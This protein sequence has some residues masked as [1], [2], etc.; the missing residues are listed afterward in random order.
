MMIT[1]GMVL[2]ERYEILG[3]IGAGGMADVY[4]GMD[5]KLNRYV[6][7]KVLKDEFAENHSFVSKFRAEA[8]A[9]AGLIH[10]N[11]VNVY[12]VGNE[13]GLYYIVMELVE[14]ITL[15]HYIEK[16]LRLSVKESISIAIQMAM[17]L[18]C[19]HRAH[20]IHRDVKPQNI[21]ISKDGKVKVTDFGIARAATSDTITSN[22]MGSVHYTS[23]EQARGGY[24]D[25]KSDIYS[26]G[27][28]LFEMLTGRVP[29]DGDSTVSIAIQHIQDTMPSPRDFVNDIPIS[30]EEII[31]KCCEKSPNR[32]YMTMTELIADLKQSLLT[33]DERFVKLVPAG[34]K[35]GATRMV[36]EEDISLIKE[37]TGSIDMDESLLNAYNRK[38]AYREDE[39][40]PEEEQPKKKKAHL[41]DEEEIERTERGGSPRKRRKPRPIEED[42]EEEERLGKKNGPSNRNEREDRGGRRDRNGS[43][44][45]YEREDRNGSSDRYEREERS[46]R[47]DRD[48]SSDRYER[49]E[50]SGRRD[51]DEEERANRN[52]R[53]SRKDRYEREE[54]KERPERY[55][56]DE[57]KERRDPKERKKREK[58]EEEKRRAKAKNTR[59]E[60]GKPEEDEDDMDPA[61]QRIMRILAVVIG[62]VILIIAVVVF[63][64]L[65]SGLSLGTSVS[66]NQEETEQSLSVAD[67][68]GKTFEEARGI[69]AAQG[70]AV[71]SENQ[72]SDTVPAGCV[73]SQ[74]PEAGEE[75]P[76]GSRIT[77]VVSSGAGGVRV[78]SLLG[79]TEA[80]A[81]VM[82]EN[83][84]FTMTV[85]K[86]P[87]EN[88]PEG[89]VTSQ[90]PEAGSSLPAGQAV[91]VI[92]STGAT[93]ATEEEGE[94]QIAVP[95]IVGLSETAA[96]TALTATKLSWS[97]M[98]EEYSDTVAVGMVISQSVPAGTMVDEGATVDFTLSLGP[99]AGEVQPQL[100]A[101]ATYGCNFS[102]TAPANYTGGDATVVL[103]GKTTGT[104]YY[105]QVVQ[106]FPV[107]IRLSGMIEPTG[108]ITVSYKV[109]T[110]VE[111][112]NP[113]GTITTTTTE[114]TKS[115]YTDVSF[116]A[117]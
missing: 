16:K 2:A 104:A 14:G 25:E 56:R 10:P 83:E 117:E 60:R 9:A 84:G 7:V 35:M 66:S 27:I 11:I 54:R 82:L 85:Q 34:G 78:P 38:R 8:Q 47:R 3:K 62:I 49:E 72:N 115:D 24:S 46:G 61:M 69:L 12:D 32:R 86:L 107:P 50:R 105:S 80:E 102:V 22:V 103:T 76:R 96:K 33:P 108:T 67:V 92:I 63:R 90:S 95:N 45:R 97:Q 114:N 98:K 55:E 99:S 73:I 26:L 37:A 111:I 71:Q 5:R 29:F 1:E 15:K 19:A 93:G 57:R 70:Y 23:P 53:G 91:D 101:V 110:T 4:R 116:T 52:E 40:W 59:N 42:T 28:V 109:K 48:G 75:A 44:D 51:R 30:V 43:S 68:A 31:F 64:R 88:V 17:G 89:L 65:F 94:G 79:R 39:P 20:I 21:I 13:D 74:S 18:E 58:A 100:P 77:L 41:F 81:R 36:S 113:D 112:P 6:A 106:A 87:D